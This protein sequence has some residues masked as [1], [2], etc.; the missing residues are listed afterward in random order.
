M[1]NWRNQ[2]D[3]H[4]LVG[5]DKLKMFSQVIESILNIK[6]QNLAPF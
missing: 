6:L 3:I 2:V 5:T 4:F 1:D